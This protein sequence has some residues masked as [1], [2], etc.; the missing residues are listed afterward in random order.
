MRLLERLAGAISG[1]RN[2][3]LEHET[4]HRLPAPDLLGLSDLPAT[5]GDTDSDYTGAV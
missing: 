1:A 2:A 4:R 3:K 5:D